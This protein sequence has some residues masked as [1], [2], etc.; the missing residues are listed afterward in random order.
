MSGTKRRPIALDE[1]PRKRRHLNKSSSSRLVEGCTS[2]SDA[3]HPDLQVQDSVELQATAPANES[4]AYTGTA[5]PASGR[6]RDSKSMPWKEA[7]YHN[8]QSNIAGHCS[9]NYNSFN[10]STITINCPSGGE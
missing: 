4:V 8:N 2:A 7:V 6:V 10:G 1:N 9:G 5:V 3:S